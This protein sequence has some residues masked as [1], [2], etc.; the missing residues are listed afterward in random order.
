MKLLEF[1]RIEDKDNRYGIDPDGE[2]DWF[3]KLETEKER[4]LYEQTTLIP[5]DVKAAFQAYDGWNAMLKSQLGVED[6]DV[7]YYFMENETPP[8]IHEHFTIDNLT[9]ERIK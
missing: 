7:F 5:S 4:E 6:D 8:E 9:F 2:N 3:V 1:K